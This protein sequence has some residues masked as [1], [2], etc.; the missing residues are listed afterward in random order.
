MQHMQSK[1]KVSLCSIRLCYVQ[2]I[3]SNF[4]VLHHPAPGYEDNYW[5]N[6]GEI[7]SF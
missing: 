5:A 2:D 7:P 1:K 6:W 3:L 4:I